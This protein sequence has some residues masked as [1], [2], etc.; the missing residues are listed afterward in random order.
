MLRAHSNWR[1]AAAFLFGFAALALPWT[2]LYFS[3]TGQ[4]TSPLFLYNLAMGCVVRGLPWIEYRTY[5]FSDFLDWRVADLL[6]KKAFFL[7]N[8]H[9]LELPTLWRLSVVFPFAV[10]G[11]VTADGIAAGLAGWLLLQL[12]W[13]ILVFS[14]LRIDGSPLDL[15]NGRYFLWFAP[16][17]LLYAAA[18]WTG[19][20]EAKA[21][22][23]GGWAVCALLVQLWAANYLSRPR[24]AE[25]PSGRPI[26][27]WPE[28]VYLREQT[29]KATHIATNIPA[30]VAWYAGRWSVNIPNRPEDLKR[31]AQ[32]HPVD[33]LLFIDHPIGEVSNLP[34]WAAVFQN[35]GGLS[36]DQ[37]FSSLGFKLEKSFPRAVLLRRTDGARKR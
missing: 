13:E 3:Q 24:I 7:F 29:D 35:H 5:A 15:M 2:A 17:V 21:W 26:G 31:L 25:H 4:V 16:F 10:L 8:I 14:F 1:H 20:R 23:W 6:V 37:S 9:I 36:P 22:R 28:L 12:G 30:Q 33:Y 34:E 11:F 32:V 27:E 18:L 19:R